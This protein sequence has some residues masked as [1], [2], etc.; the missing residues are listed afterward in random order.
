MLPLY[1]IMDVALESQDVY[2]SKI[3]NVTQWLECCFVTAGVARSIRVVSE[4]LYKIKTSIGD[5]IKFL[6]A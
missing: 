6:K 3:G 4:T 5:I 1:H 2:K